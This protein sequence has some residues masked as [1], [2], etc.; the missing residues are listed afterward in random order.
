MKVGDRVT[1]YDIMQGL[2]GATG[3]VKSVTV[4]RVKGSL[5]VEWCSVLPDGTGEDVRVKSELLVKEDS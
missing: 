5:E 1:V 4:E 2:M 3:V